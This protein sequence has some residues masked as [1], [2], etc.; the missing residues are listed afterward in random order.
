MMYWRNG[1]TFLRI[2]SLF[3]QNS[4]LLF[5]LKTNKETSAH[6]MSHQLKA[7][8]TILDKYRRDFFT[9]LELLDHNLNKRTTMWPPPIPPKTMYGCSGR[10]A[11]Y[12]AVSQHC[13]GGRASRWEDLHLK[14]WYI[15]YIWYG[16]EP[17]RPGGVPQW[18]EKSSKQKSVS[19]CAKE[20]KGKEGD[21]FRVNVVVFNHFAPNGV[22]ETSK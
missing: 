9:F 6:M 19:V 22:P 10:S 13:F 11:I 21:S 15:W 5:E 1:L 14:N 2:P 16:Q 7:K 12:P 18:T 17:F 8:S 20:E 3:K 4:K